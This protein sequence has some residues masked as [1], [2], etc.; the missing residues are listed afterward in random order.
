[1]ALALVPSAVG[2]AAVVL[3]GTPNSCGDLVSWVLGCDNTWTGLGGF[4]CRVSGRAYTSVGSNSK[5]GATASSVLPQRE[6]D[7]LSRLRDLRNRKKRTAARACVRVF[8]LVFPPVSAE[9]RML[10][11][12]SRDG[13]SDSFCFFIFH[14]RRGVSFFLFFFCHREQQFS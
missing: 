9:K 1:M 13:R 5:K 3:C 4:Y 2:D 7:G 10:C 12:L 11:A 8:A 6:T 14:K